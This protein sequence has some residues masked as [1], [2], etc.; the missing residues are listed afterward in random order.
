V[1]GRA[2]KYLGAVKYFLEIHLGSSSSTVVTGSGLV[3]WV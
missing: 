2:V 1:A 3:R